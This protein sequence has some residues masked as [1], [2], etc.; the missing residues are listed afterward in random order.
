MRDTFSENSSSNC[1]SASGLIYEVSYNHPLADMVILNSL[2]MLKLLKL[3][4]S[5]NILKTIEH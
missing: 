4:Y 1:K 5:F 2:R 3:A